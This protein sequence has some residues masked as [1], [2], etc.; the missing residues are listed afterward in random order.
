MTNGNWVCFA[1]LTMALLV[2]KV[3]AQD[4]EPWPSPDELK[5]RIRKAFQPPKDC[6]AL[7]PKDCIWIQK[8]QQAVIL[9]GFVAQRNAPLE[10]FACPAGSKEHESVVSVLAR[11]KIVHAGL[12]AVGAKPGSPAKFE[13]FRPATGTTIRIYA[14][15]FDEKGEK[16]GTIAQNWVRK[17]GTKEPLKSDW[18]F[19]G[20]SE[21]VD[22]TT[23]ERYYMAESGELI[24]VANFGTSTMDIV[25]RSDQGNEILSFDAFTENI[26]KRFSPVRLVLTLTDEKPYGSEPEHANQDPPFLK[27]KVPDY[28]LDWL[29][30]AETK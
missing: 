25:V 3:R 10:M 7:H 1:I 4:D 6:K 5:A 16:K 29:E 23:K 13:P 9:D 11:P 21:Y 24:C 28:I 18:V 2:P 15:W 27:E 30:K 26:P 17:M 8:D 12:L 19:G 14:L 20:S 22:E